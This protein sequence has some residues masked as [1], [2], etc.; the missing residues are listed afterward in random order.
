MSDGLAV[1]RRLL[2]ENNLD[3]AKNL[4]GLAMLYRDDGKRDQAKELVEEA[5]RIQRTLLGDRDLRVADTL[6]VLGSVSGPTP[7]SVDAY[8][9]ALSIQKQSLGP[10]HPRVAITL[11]YLARKMEDLNDFGDQPESLLREALRRMGRQDLTTHG[12]RSTFSDWCAERTAFPAEVREIALA[13]TVGDK[14]EHVAL[15][16]LL[17]TEVTQQVLREASQA[18]GQ[19]LD[20]PEDQQASRAMR[21]HLTKVLL[22]RCVAELLSRPELKSWGFA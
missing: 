19:A 16:N 17:N 12:F 2:G 10:D 3:T 1:R 5:L 15:P 7:A 13:H 4:V 8:Q 21:H 6:V 18:L 20:P 14:A 22:A 11:T 9:K